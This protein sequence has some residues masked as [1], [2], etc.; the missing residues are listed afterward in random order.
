[1]PYKDKS[2]HRTDKIALFRQPGDTDE[3]AY[4]RYRE[5]MRQIAATGGRKTSGYG[6]A[7]GKLDAVETGKKGGRPRVKPNK[8]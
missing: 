4:D 1:M 2:K 6:F 8:V 3:Q 5:S 7:H